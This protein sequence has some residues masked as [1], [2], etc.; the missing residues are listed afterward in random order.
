MNQIPLPNKQTIDGIALVPADLAHPQSVGLSSNPSDLHTS[1]GQVD[2]EEHHEA[3]SATSPYFHGEE[4][5]CAQQF[6]VTAQE[7]LPARLTVPLRGWLDAV[8]FQDTGDRA[9]GNHVSRLDNAP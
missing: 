6:P 9:G 5:S 4:V 7:L 1:T 2:E 8:F 3:Q